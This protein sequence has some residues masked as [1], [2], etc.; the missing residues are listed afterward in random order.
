MNCYK[1]VKFEHLGYSVDYH[2][3]GKFYGSKTIEFADRETIGYCGKKEEI[4]T[5]DIIFKN[6]RIKKG[7][8][9]YTYL[10]PLCGRS[11]INV[12]IK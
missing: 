8:K 6:K 11:N 4:A 7:M 12:N 5:D 3:D 9:Y 10:Y 2:V 1:N